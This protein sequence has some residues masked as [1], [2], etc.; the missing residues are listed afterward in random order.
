MKHLSHLD[1]RQDAVPDLGAFELGSAARIRSQIKRNFSAILDIS[2]N[3]FQPGTEFKVRLSLSKPL[4]V[5][6]DLFNLN[7]RR[8]KNFFSGRLKS[9]NHQK[10]WSIENSE[11]DDFPS[12]VYFFRVKVGANQ[13][14]Q[15]MT[16]IR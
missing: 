12:G 2:P 11:G 13:V 14:G 6:A 3:P 10:V 7:G 1:R 4:K 9:G 5:S 16:K 15:S 8:V